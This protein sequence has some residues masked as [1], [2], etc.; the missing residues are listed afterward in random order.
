[1]T[2]ELTE[3]QQVILSRLLQTEIINVTNSAY[4]NA[5]ELNKEHVKELETLHSLV[6][7]AYLKY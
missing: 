4:I 2:I 1:M 5:E 7:P 6:S 3:K